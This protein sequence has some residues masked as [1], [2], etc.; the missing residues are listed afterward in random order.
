MH[1]LGHPRGRIYN[2]RAGLSADW[3]RV[4]AEASSLDK[5]VEI[6]CFPDRQD[7]NVELLKLARAAGTRVSL[8]TDAHHPWQLA[9]IE[10]G[11]AAPWQAKLPP[12]RVVNFMTMAEI[13]R[14]ISGLRRQP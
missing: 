11:L 8:G 4:F 1:I 3:S 13:R 9:F 7:L 5:A 2:Y 6:D 12:E 10:F 14:W